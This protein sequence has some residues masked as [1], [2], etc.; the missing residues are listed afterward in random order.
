MLGFVGGLVLG[1]V[2][3]DAFGW[4]AVFAI[5]VP[6]GVTA[7][8]AGIRAL[9]PAARVPTR[10][11]VLGAV[12]VTGAVALI[13]YAPSRGS[14]SGFASPGF[15]LPLAAGV[16]ALAL[17]VFWE[18]RAKVPLVRLGM[19]RSRQLRTA[20]LVMLT[21]GAM[22]G[23]GFLLSALYLQNGL[24]FSPALAGLG[25]APMGLVGIVVGMLGSRVLGRLGVR[26]TTT[27]A[28]G[29]S[30]VAVAL[31]ALSMAPGGHYP[32]LLVGLIV[33][34]L[35]F[36]LMSAS[37]RVA[38][39]MGV[40]DEEQGLAGGLGQTSFQVGTALGVAVLLTL[41][42]DHSAGLGIPGPAATVAG[43]RLALL[44]MAAFGAAVAVLAGVGLR[45]TTRE[46]T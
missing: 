1:G 13:V 38:A 5:N 18:R 24:G 21:S 45:P 35:G 14:E 27:L 25:I 42:V 19:L 43:Y 40:A 33:M 46:E 2:L 8:I 34:G 10:V 30:A 23:V 17:F 15:I 36:P 6:V 32:L 28:T 39:S 31:L 26:I 22:N 37:S 11:D 29:L 12:L 3:V 41:A 4:R 44:M 20:N 7:V 16:V 9:P